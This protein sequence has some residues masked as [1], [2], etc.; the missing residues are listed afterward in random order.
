MVFGYHHH[1]NNNITPPLCAEDGSLTQPERKK[2]KKWVPEPARHIGYLII[3][4]PTRKP[5]N[6]VPEHRVSDPK[7]PF[8]QP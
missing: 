1:H 3:G 8:A 4:Y 6:R 7:N 2:K 5:A